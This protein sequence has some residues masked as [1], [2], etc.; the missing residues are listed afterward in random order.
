MAALSFHSMPESSTAMT[1]S[2]RPVLTCQAV[3]TAPWAQ[4]EAGCTGSAS[5]RLMPRIPHISSACWFT[6]RTSGFPSGLAGVPDSRQSPVSL[7][8]SGTCPGARC[9][10]PGP[11]PAG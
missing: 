10:P 1:T 2:G 4:V 8:S 6:F 3:R 5:T 11:V 9:Q 7:N